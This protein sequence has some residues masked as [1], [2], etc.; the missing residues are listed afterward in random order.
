MVDW[1]LRDLTVI[2]FSP[3]WQICVGCRANARVQWRHL[4]SERLAC[5]FFCDDPSRWSSFDY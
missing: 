1:R 4:Q 3:Q 2:Q 5:E